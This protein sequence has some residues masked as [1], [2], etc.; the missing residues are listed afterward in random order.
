[1]VGYRQ[2]NGHGTDGLAPDPGPPARRSRASGAC[3]QAGSGAVEKK[4]EIHRRFKRQVRSG[5]P[6]RA[7]RLL[8]LQRLLAQP[9]Q[10]TRRGQYPPQF[11][12]KWKPP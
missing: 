5:H 11:T 7:E 2:A 1:M 9:L 12:P 4:M 8:Q 6:V 3:G 10:W